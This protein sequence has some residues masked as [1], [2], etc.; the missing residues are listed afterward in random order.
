MSQSLA[1]IIRTQGKSIYTSKAVQRRRKV[2]VNFKNAIFYPSLQKVEVKQ[3]SFRPGIKEI[4]FSQAFYFS[5]NCEGKMSFL[6]S[7]T[8]VNSISSQI[9]P[10]TYCRSSLLFPSPFVL[11]DL[12]LCISSLKVHMSSNRKN[13]CSPN[14]QNV[15]DFISSVLNFLC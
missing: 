1:Y 2:I 15:L 10:F 11:L 9:S 12:L 4:F 13:F 3:Y 7:M 8:D 5:N 6:I 14:W